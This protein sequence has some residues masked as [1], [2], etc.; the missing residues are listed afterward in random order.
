MTNI[1]GPDISFYQ[2][3]NETPQGVDFVKMR[4]VTDWVII[5]A[6]QNTWIDPD[7]KTNWTNAKAA[8]LRR[9]SY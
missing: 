1:I 7:F 3:D 4:T 9:G 8:G 2:D 5:R 6:G